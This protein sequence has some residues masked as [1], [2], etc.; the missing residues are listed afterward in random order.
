MDRYV[1]N[2]SAAIAGPALPRSE[3]ETEVRMATVLNAAV[4]LAQ[5]ERREKGLKSDLVS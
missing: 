5:H 2:A 3:Y 4:D 1:A